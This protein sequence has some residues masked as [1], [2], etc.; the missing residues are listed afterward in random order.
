MSQ[1]PRFCFVGTSSQNKKASPMYLF[2]VCILMKQNT[3]IS[4]VFWNHTW[5][6]SRWRAIS[7]M[8]SEVNVSEFIYRLFH[9][10]F[11]SIVGTNIAA[12]SQLFILKFFYT[13]FI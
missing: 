7:T 4:N 1:I 2:N 8:I 3:Y 9:E 11:Y 12:Y 6:S 13:S 5:W 10:G